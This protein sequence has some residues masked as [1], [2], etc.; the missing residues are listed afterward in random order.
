MLLRKIMA[1]VFF[2]SPETTKCQNILVAILVLENVKKILGEAAA[3]F[4]LATGRGKNSLAFYGF[5]ILQYG[6]I[7]LKF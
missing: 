6:Y 2:W 5:C 3:K 4:C 1:N 7:F